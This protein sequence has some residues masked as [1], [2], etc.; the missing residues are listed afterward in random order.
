MV[1]SESIIRAGSES[2]IDPETIL[3][4][5][6]SLSAR[7]GLG[8]SPG[9]GPVRVGARSGLGPIMALMGLKDTILFKESLILMKS[10]KIVNKDI[11]DVKSKKKKY[12]RGFAIRT[13]LS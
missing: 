12:K 2:E 8:P 10:H 13:C 6:F 9:W 5:R 3:R 7:A 11:K 1:L 4:N